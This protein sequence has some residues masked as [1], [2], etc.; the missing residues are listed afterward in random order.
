MRRGATSH[1]VWSLRAERRSFRTVTVR[2]LPRD[3][4]TDATQP[5]LPDRLRPPA[6]SRS[7]LLPARRYR[8]RRLRR[9]GRQV[10]RL[11]RPLLRER[12]RFGAGGPAARLAHDSIVTCMRPHPRRRGVVL[13]RELVRPARRRH[14]SAARRACEG[15]GHPP[16]PLD[17]R[18][19]HLH[20]RRRAR[21]HRV[22]LGKRRDSGAGADGTGD[23]QPGPRALRSLAARHPRAQLHGDRRGDAP[24]VRHRVDGRDVLLGLQLPR[25]DGEHG[26]R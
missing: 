1:D 19:R 6:P 23:V 2:S 4:S 14:R 18:W 21:R 7:R 5:S 8:W 13:G 15:R 9:R 25:R 16:V 24:R 20:V 12:A 17:L 26:L 3:P 10:G 11:L 22:L